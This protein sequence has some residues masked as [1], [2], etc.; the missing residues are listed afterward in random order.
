MKNRIKLTESQLN[1]VIRESVKQTL[2]ELDSAGASFNP[3]E[4]F[5]F[6]GNFYEGFAIVKLNGKWNYINTSGELLS[7]NQWFD[8]CYEFYNGLARVELNGEWNFIDANGD[9]LSDTWFDDC[10]GFNDGF[11]RVKLDNKYNYINANCEL[12]SPNQWFDYCYNF[13]NGFG[14]VNLGWRWYTID[15]KGQFYTE[16]GEPLQE[17]RRY[18]RNKRLSE[19]QLNNVIRRAI[20]NSLR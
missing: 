4:R 11:A 17:N 8:D 2:S 9:Y 10:W 20:R 1:R 12:L 16:D 19:A 13:D 7:P 18:R 14:K 6:C 15:T 5:D 3:D